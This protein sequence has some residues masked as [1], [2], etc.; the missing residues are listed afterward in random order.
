M[1]N[2]PTKDK[3]VEHYDTFFLYIFMDVYMYMKLVYRFKYIKY[4]QYFN[5]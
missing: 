4:I 1:H 5:R 2:R 3:L